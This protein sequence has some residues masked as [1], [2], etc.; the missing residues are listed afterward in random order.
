[1]NN[2]E[3]TAYKAFVAHRKVFDTWENGNI[4]KV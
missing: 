3:L 4:D 2:L 1:M